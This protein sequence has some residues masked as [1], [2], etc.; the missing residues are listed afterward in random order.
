MKKAAIVPCKGIGDGLIMMVAAYA[1][2]QKGYE[3]TLYHPHMGE[4]EDWFFP[5]FTISD[6]EN[7][8]SKIDSY[9][10]IIAQNDNSPFLYR[11]KEIQKSSAPIHVIYPTYEKGKHLIT[12]KDSI[13]PNELPIARALAMTMQTLLQDK[14][15]IPSNGMIYNDRF[16]HRK[17]LKR[18][19]LHPTSTAKDRTWSQKK[20]LITYD[21]LEKKGFEP[22]FAVSQ[23]EENEWQEIMSKG[24]RVISFPTLSQLAGYLYESGYLIGNESGLSH[25]A[26]SLNIPTLVIA[27]LKERI[28]Q[29]QPGWAVGRVIYP[30]SFIPNIKGLRLRDHYWQNFISPSKVER[31]FAKLT[32]LSVEKAA[33][34]SQ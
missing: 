14:G 23:K 5:F 29:W 21:R 31:E 8:F 27:G 16:I 15:L 13:L 24:Y 1:L 33:Y 19:V 2:Y 17:H 32:V 9:D 12:A 30:P 22:V 20:F 4:L 25:L 18:V 11:L 10:Y 7:L 26:S 34:S 6:K 28:L 3:I